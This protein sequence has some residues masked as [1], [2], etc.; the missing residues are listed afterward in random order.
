M[1]QKF[2]MKISEA[3]GTGMERIF[4]NKR[5]KKFAFFVFISDL[6]TTIIGGMTGVVLYLLIA[7]FVIIC[8]GNPEFIG[9]EINNKK[10]NQNEQN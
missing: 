7:G 2:N 6:T 5:L 4:N 10:E 3:F 8:F 1:K 9:L